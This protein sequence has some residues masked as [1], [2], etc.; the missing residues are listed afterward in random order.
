MPETVICDVYGRKSTTDKAVSIPGQLKDCLDAIE[1]RSRGGELWQTGETYADPEISA[2][3]FA[4]KQRPEFNALVASYKTYKPKPG[5]RRALAIWEC[6]RGSREIGEWVALMV[7]CREKRILILAADEDRVYDPTNRRD[8]RKLIEEGLD[9]ADESERTS[10]RCRRGQR[11]A[12]EGG[13]PQGRLVYG[14]ARTYDARGV[15]VEQVAHPEHS[16]IVTEIFNRISV[17]ASL[18]E[19][20]KDLNDRKVPP[21]MAE[22][23]K[24]PGQRWYPS[25]VRRIAMRETYLGRRVHLG[26]VTAE[27]CWPALVEDGAYRKCVRILSEP[28]RKTANV[29]VLRYP[30][31]GILRC[32]D[33]RCGAVMHAK[34]LRWKP[35][36]DPVRLYQCRLCGLSM[37]AD[38]LDGYVIAAVKGRLKTPGAAHLF[39]VPSP[40]SEAGAAALEHEDLLR[41]LEGYYDAAEQRQ[42]SQG[43]LIAME[44]RLLP[45]IEDAKRRRDAQS[46]PAVL[47]GFTPDDVIDGWDT[48]TVARKRTVIGGACELVIARGT[49]GR[50]GFDRSRLGG[51]RWRGDSRTWADIWAAES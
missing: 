5:E 31:S 16:P 9:A 47:D 6:S 8:F 24:R 30:L 51:S 2:S 35:N 17:G 21:P 3:R 20:A 42:L 34:W 14:Y 12:A 36:P 22:S 44:R 37:R 38:G 45:K 15:F 32:G 48:F 49:P 28:G 29:H 18:H 7:E 40:G 19:I 27:N 39:N 26:V 43:G 11:I 10:E 4:R 25:A 33:E 23:E 50:R 13:R 46:I 41:E 1:R